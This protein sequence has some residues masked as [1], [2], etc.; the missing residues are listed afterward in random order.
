MFET[1]VIAIHSQRPQRRAGLFTISVAMHTLVVVAAVTAGISSI[2]F[3][4]NAPNQSETFNPIIPIV[5]P[6]GGGGGAVQ[7][8]Q[9]PAEKPRPAQQ[10]QVTAPPEQVAPRVTPDAIPNV[11]A[12]STADIGTPGPAGP[13]VGNPG[14]GPGIGD[15]PGPVGP[16]VGEG[17]ATVPVPNVIFTPGADVR[18]ATV[19]S[20]VAPQYPALPL[21]MH[22]G[23][24]V[25]VHCVIDRNGRIREPQVINSTSTLFNQAAIDAV[26]QWT[27][28]PGTM[29]G[30]AVDTYFELKVT[31][32]VK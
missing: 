25:T 29:H 4:T 2:S 18:A 23:G 26:Q 3:P 14:P 27:F 21:K 12:T 20:R 32:S 7:R 8:P 1:S 24:T 17:P 15:G 22:M 6:P 16:G 9:P 30:Q 13:G 28:A 31:F 5:M 19:I 11:A 10:Q